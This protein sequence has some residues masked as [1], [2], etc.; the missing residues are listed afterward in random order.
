MKLPFVQKGGCPQAQIPFT[1]NQ[2]TLCRRSW[3]HTIMLCRMMQVKKQ[4]LVR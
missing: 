3:L 2:G 4:S 1:V